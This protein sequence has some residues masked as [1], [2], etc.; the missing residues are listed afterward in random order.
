MLE[1]QGKSTSTERKLHMPVASYSQTGAIHNLAAETIPF[2]K[3]EFVEFLTSAGVPE[4]T[5]RGS[6]FKEPVKVREYLRQAVSSADSYSALG[7]ACL[8][9]GFAYSGV[10]HILVGALAVYNQVRAQKGFDA[11]YSVSALISPR[12]TNSLKLMNLLTAPGAYR[13]FQVGVYVA[14]AFE[15][16]WRGEY[17]AASAMILFI[18]GAVSLAKLYNQGRLKNDW[19]SFRVGK[20]LSW[21]WE[22]ASGRAKELLN[23]PALWWA[24]AY[25]P[26]GILNLKPSLFSISAATPIAW[27]AILISPCILLQLFRDRRSNEPKKNSKKPLQA[28]AVENLLSAVATLSQGTDPTV[29][30]AYLLY[31]VSTNLIANKAKEASKNG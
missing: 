18:F 31:F 26:L 5:A 9:H 24:L 27:G 2:L 17:V 25:I 22:T 12:R 19:E 15:A 3:V 7:S 1:K 21:F 20:K 6:V 4:N 30:A 14:N 29:A 13:V 10:L 16:V 28:L 8:V 23:S 11:N